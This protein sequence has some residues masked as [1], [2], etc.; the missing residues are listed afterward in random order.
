MIVLDLDKD[1]SDIYQTMSSLQKKLCIELIKLR[2]DFILKGFSPTDLTVSC[3]IFNF[4]SDSAEFSPY[5]YISND[6]TKYKIGIFLGFEVYIDLDLPH[7][8]I[9][10]SI[11]KNEIR[12]LKIDSILFDDSINEFEIKR[13]K[14]KSSLI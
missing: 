12:D 11:D 8:E 4:I 3:R 10:M 14:V 5:V 6:E 1:S 9:V 13:V 7:D 2:N